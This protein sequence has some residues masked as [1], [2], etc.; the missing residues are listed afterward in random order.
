[1]IEIFC[2]LQGTCTLFL[3]DLKRGRF[4]IRLYYFNVSVLI[5]YLLT[6]RTDLE[7]FF[8]LIAG[9]S[10]VVPFQSGPV[11]EVDIYC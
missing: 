11:P 5:S 1:M 2:V 9:A 10:R 6:R 8:Y 3:K 4:S 7:D